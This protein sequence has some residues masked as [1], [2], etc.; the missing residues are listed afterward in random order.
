MLWGRYPAQGFYSTAALETVEISVSGR[1]RAIKTGLALEV[2]GK[3]AT[4][5]SFFYVLFERTGLRRG[6]FVRDCERARTFH[7]STADQIMIGQLFTGEKQGTQLYGSI[8][9]IALAD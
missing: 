8:L 5:R 6:P 4:V 2:P 9:E 1:E 3:R 7:E